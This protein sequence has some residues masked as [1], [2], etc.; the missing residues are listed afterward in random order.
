MGGTV[1]GQRGWAV[2]GTRT[3]TAASTSLFSSLSSP[4]SSF[5]T[6]AIVVSSHS[7]TSVTG[8]RAW[9]L[10]GSWALKAKRSGLY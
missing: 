8:K 1:V 3:V 7:R 6:T 5:T 4:S 10:L 9:L 2:G